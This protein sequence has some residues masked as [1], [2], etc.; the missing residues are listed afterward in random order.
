MKSQSIDSLYP[1]L[2]TGDLILFSGQYRMSKLVE[3]LEN[4]MWSHVG[5]VYR[6]NPEGEVY[7]WEST[8]L[9]NLQDEVMHDNLTGPKIVKLIDRL[10]TYGQDVVPYQPPAYAWRSLE[11][12]QP[13][14]EQAF[15]HY[16]KKVHGIPNPSEWNMIKEVMEG[17]IFSIPSKAKD[18]TCSKLIG[19]TYQELGIASFTMPLNGLMPKD[20]SS[21][22][23]MQMIQ[24]ELGEEVLIEVKGAGDRITL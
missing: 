4:S 12:N 18:Y 5:M 15:L 8:A 6:P 1:E 17:R 21:S 10:K 13:V 11:H 2:K 24:C 3:K 23:R 9:T 22:G 16:M 20:F 19:E 7:F 14:D